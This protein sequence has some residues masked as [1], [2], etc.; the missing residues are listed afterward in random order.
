MIVLPGLIILLAA[1]IVAV[2]G[3]LA[4]GRRAAHLPPRTRRPDRPARHRPR[5]RGERP[6]ERHGTQ[7]SGSRL[8]WQPRGLAALVQTHGRFPVGHR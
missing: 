5:L 1:V 7:Q 6:G 4:N 3:V 2:A 8:R